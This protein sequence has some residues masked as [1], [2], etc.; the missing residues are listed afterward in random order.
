MKKIL[1]ISLLNL[2]A[3]F[4]SAQIK[5]LDLS[6]IPVNE[7]SSDSITVWVQFKARN[8]ADIQT[9]QLNFETQNGMAD[10]LQKTATVTQ[11]ANTY[12]TQFENQST[13]IE[14]YNISLY[15]K[16]TKEQFALYNIARVVVQYNDNS[17]A[18]LV[19]NND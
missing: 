13:P 5:L 16:M 19:L 18:F 8:I 1:F 12:Y 11:Q 15:C 9:V 3:M 7:P 6:V 17:S 14:N 4:A 2:L 10:V